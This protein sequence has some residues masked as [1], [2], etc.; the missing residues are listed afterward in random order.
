MYVGMAGRGGQR[1]TASTGPF[2][3][4]ASH[5]S[6]RRSG[7]QFCVHVCDRLVLPGL[8]DRL[9]EVADGSLSLDRETRAYVRANLAF[10]FVAVTDGAAALKLEREVRAGRLSGGRRVDPDPDPGTALLPRPG[11]PANL[12]DGSRPERRAAR[13]NSEKPCPEWPR[14]AEGSFS[15][16]CRSSS[17]RASVAILRHSDEAH[18]F[19]KDE[20]QAPGMRARPPPLAAR[21]SRRAAGR[22][23]RGRR[24]LVAALP[25]EAEARARSSGG[26]SRPGGSSARTPSFGGGRAAVRTPSTSGGY[27]RPYGT[28][29]SYTSRLPSTAGPSGDRAF[30]RQQ[31]AD[32]LGRTATSKP[33]RGRRKR[34][35]SLRRHRP[36][37][38][39]LTEAAERQLRPGRQP[40]GPSAGYRSGWFGSRGWTA[41]DYAYRSRPSFGVWD[42]LFLWF[43]LDNLTRPGYGD[44]FYNHQND[45]G[46][47]QWRAEAERLARENADVRRSSTPSTG[48]SR[49]SRASRGTPTTCR[50]TRR[51]RSPSP[52]ARTTPA[53]RAPPP[54]RPRTREG[55]RPR[56]ADCC[57]PGARSCS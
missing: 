35:A 48:K 31:S 46:Y 15:V 30:S 14:A 55:R 17:C 18:A 34:P 25:G 20:P 5:A 52:P 57:S 39:G 23:D 42:G 41:P 54:E 36:T 3:R 37:G 44:F 51:P 10:R 7:D 50:P 6:G 24:V 16:V 49:P 29:P 47:Q 27:G 12:P 26:Y 28:S 8:R 13:S 32:A 45:P 53:R 33:R 40:Y 38:R 43:L 56:G 11:Q 21:P 2:G 9:A 19:R 1:S 22:R 4:L